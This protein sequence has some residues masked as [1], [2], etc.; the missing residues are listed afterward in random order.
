MP[1]GHR[2]AESPVPLFPLV[3]TKTKIRS[4]T[5]FLFWWNDVFRCA[6]RD[7]C[8]A[9]D[10]WLRQMM[11]AARVK[12]GTH[13]ITLRRSRKTSRLPQGKHIISR[14][15]GIH[16]KTESSEPTVKKEGRCPAGIVM[17]RGT[18]RPP[19]AAV[20]P[21]PRFLYSPSS[22]QWCKTACHLLMLR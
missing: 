1:G 22:P 6:E 14:V 17:P 11:C 19:G 3:S 8:C 16:H 5:G 18:G 4:L 20:M 2:F 7:A 21:S 15:S 13:H 12:S 9:H 10:V